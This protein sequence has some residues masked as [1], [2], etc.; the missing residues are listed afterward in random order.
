LNQGIDQ[1]IQLQFH[2]G[3]EIPT[4]GCTDL[5][6]TAVLPAASRS[7]R[8]AALRYSIAGFSVTAVI[9]FA[10]GAQSDPERIFVGG[11]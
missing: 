4:S 2:D 1:S 3:F 7:E 10:V 5:T 11:R 8:C 6:I 9:A